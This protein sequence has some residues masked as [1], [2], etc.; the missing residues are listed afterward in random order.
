[1]DYRLP[2]YMAY[3][4]PMDYDNERIEQRDFEY[5]KSM[6][7]ETA[8]RLLPY[9]E[10]ECDRMEY[11]GSVIY[12]EYPDRLQ[13]QLMTNRIY[14]RAKNV[15]DIN[16]EMDMEAQ[17]QSRRRRGENNLKELIQLILFQELFRR[18]N[19]HRRNRRRFY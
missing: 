10:E 13:M 2:Y 14:D 15:D 5:M 12:D 4:M 16:K 18:R 9:V 19:S 8:K 17:Q 6:Y 11:E 1:M 3:P 7:P